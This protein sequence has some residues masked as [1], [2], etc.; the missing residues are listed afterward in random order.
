MP[1]FQRA[2]VALHSSLS[3]RVRIPQEIMATALG[4]A[5]LLFLYESP[6]DDLVDGRLDERR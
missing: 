1:G 2:I 5:H 3:T 6:T 4:P